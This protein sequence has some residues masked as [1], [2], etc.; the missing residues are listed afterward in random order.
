VAKSEREPNQ[1]G[2]RESTVEWRPRIDAYPVDEANLTIFRI[3]SCTCP[4][5]NEASFTLFGRMAGYGEHPLCR[6]EIQL[7]RHTNPKWFSPYVIAPWVL[8]KHIYSEQAIRRGHP[9]DKCAS[10]LLKT[11]PRRRFSLQQAIGRIS[12]IFLDENLIEIHGQNSEWMLF[13]G[14]GAEC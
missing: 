4:A 12:R 14:G 13:H 9:W 7:C 8:H 5:R 1:K 11:Q 10:P 2:G 3:E 6:Y